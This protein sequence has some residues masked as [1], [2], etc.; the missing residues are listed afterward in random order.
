MKK[1][2]AIL[3]V[4]AL[5][6]SLCSCAAMKANEENAKQAAESY[7][8]AVKDGREA[9][10]AGC[11]HPSTQGHFRE[12]CTR[13]REDLPI[14]EGYTLEEKYVQIGS[15][16]GLDG[17][18]TEV[19]LEYKLT[20]GGESYTAYVTYRSDAK[21]AGLTDLSLTKNIV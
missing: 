19:K 18:Y 21:G 6:V 1:L 20:C 8:A 16:A 10:A 13:L 7:F 15:Y 3:L 12:L 11:A 5:L 9:D 2:L 17:T 14:A 4:A